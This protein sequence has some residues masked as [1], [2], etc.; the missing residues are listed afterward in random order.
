MAIERII[1]THNFTTILPQIF[2]TVSGRRA[3]AGPELQRRLAASRYSEA[4]VYQRGLYLRL[5]DDCIIT[6]HPMI[7]DELC[8]LAHSR[9]PMRWA[10][11]RGGLEPAVLALVQRH[12]P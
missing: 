5:S 12:M 2:D 11:G 10:W 8:I 9:S 6:L 3:Q 1:I 7:H 4:R